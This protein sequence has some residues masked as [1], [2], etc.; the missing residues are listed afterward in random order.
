MNDVMRMVFSLSLSGT[1][2]IVV[3]FLCKPFYKN[4]ISR[5][6]QYYIWLV[7]IARLLIPFAPKQNLMGMMFDRMEQATA[8]QE[9][10]LSEQSVERK[11]G[12]LEQPTQREAG[13]AEQL[14][15]REVGA[16][17]QV[18]EKEAG[19]AEQLAEQP[20][21]EKKTESGLKSSESVSEADTVS[22]GSYADRPDITDADMQPTASYITG[23]NAADIL[24]YLWLIWLGGAAFLLIR[25]VTVY[26]SFVK[27]IRAGREEVSDIKLLDL[28]AETEEQMGIKRPVELYTNTLVCSPLLLGLFRPC[29]ILPK[30]DLPG[31]DLRYTIRHELIHYRRFDLL[32]KWLVQIT[33]CLHW[34]NPFVWLM[35][36]ETGRACEL[37]CDEALAGGLDAR[38]RRAYGDT[39][40]RAAKGGGGDGFREPV[41]SLTLSE[42]G[43][44][45]KERLG[46]ITDFR[47]QPKAV[48][49]LSAFL[50]AV[51]ILGGVMTGAA[52]PVSSGGLKGNDTRSMESDGAAGKGAGSMVS[53]GAVGKDAG[54]TA[55]DGAAS[56]DGNA[57]L[58]E[59]NASME[60]LEFKGVT[61]Y[62]VFNEAQL[63]A[64]GTGEY[65]TDKNYMQQADIRM[66]TDEW[67]PLGTMDEPFTGS[68][69]GN[70]FEIIGLT[71]ADEE[72]ELAGMFGAARDAHIYNITLRDH[73]I[74]NKNS[75]E[76][77]DFPILACDLGGNRVYDNIVYLSDEIITGVP[78]TDTNKTK[79]PGSAGRET[80][81][82]AGEY[83]ENGDI[84]GFGRAFS[85][86]DESSRKSWLERIYADEEIAFFSVSLEQI[87]TGSPLIGCFAQKAY[88]DGRIAFFAVLTDHMD[89][90]ALED[91][92][93]QAEA[94][95]KYNFES[96]LLIALDRDWEKAA[97]QEELDRQREEEYRSIGITTNGK[98]RYYQGQ[99][100]NVFLDMQQPDKAFYLLDMNPDGT[101]NV[102]IVR[103]EDGKIQGAAYMTDAEVKALFGDNE[104]EDIMVPISIASVE[105]KE[106]IWLGTYELE[107]GDTISYRLSA[108]EG[109]R[110]DVGFA[111]AGETNPDTVYCHI[112]N[113]RQNNS[114]LEIVSDNM[115]WGDIPG[116][117]IYS[118]YV[119]TRGGNLKNVTGSVRIVKAA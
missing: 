4:R 92:L 106:F 79:A 63:R 105:D 65:G 12:S 90:N 114:K 74:K 31:E 104:E 18:T 109:E 83:Y 14:E 32:Y 5:R 84:P 26:Q 76:Q 35:G 67:K 96:V 71:A 55:S 60:T 22:T 51:L 13:S 97:L 28:L 9:A 52:A 98:L 41:V 108:K 82:K 7:V 93:D 119:H 62:L 50:A 75:A 118:L 102:K 88:E 80:A 8:E 112:S 103:D 81:S 27:C 70:G 16:P 66:S 54:S 6:W 101:V 20:A 58:A 23:K 46:A 115:V 30:T 25:R 53:G 3:L 24:Q 10:G 89:K 64:I 111:K 61:Y 2:L 37:A 113:K 85:V 17:E 107:P 34:F 1:L 33:V 87:E 68:Y 117:G 94:D 45:L 11:A 72:T 91:W 29:I 116:T 86:L 73:N 78:G 44:L 49:A 77:P 43:K 57:F 99:L 95:G 38:G 110:L 15:E 36:K 59:E 100:V 40:L 19:S 47:K 56:A 42:N 21:E 39:L 48:K 69:N